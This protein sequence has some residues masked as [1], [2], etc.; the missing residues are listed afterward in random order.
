MDA[1]LIGLKTIRLYWSIFGPCLPHAVESRFEMS[2]TDLNKAFLKFKD[3]AMDKK[4]KFL[5]GL[6]AIAN[7]ELQSTE[8][9]F[10]LGWCKF[11]VAIAPVLLQQSLWMPN[12]E[13]LTDATGTGPL[14]LST[15]KSTALKVPNQ[16]ISSSR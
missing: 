13:E 12:G 9:I 15:S 14:M 11:P 6:K 7:D 5:I 2:D 3:L 10:R 4:K 8:E 16:L 1:Q